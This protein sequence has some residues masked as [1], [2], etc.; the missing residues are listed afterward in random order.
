MKIDIDYGYLFENGII[1]P[2]YLRD[3]QIPLYKMLQHENRMVIDCRRRFGKTTVLLVYIL[4]ECLKR[5]GLKV[6]WGSPE[7]IQ[8]RKIVF[9]VMDQIYSYSPKHKPK[10][11]HFMGAYVYPNNSK[12]YLFGAGDSNELDKCRGQEA[13]IIV[14]DEYG[15]FKF[16]PDYILKSVLNPMLLYTNGQLIMSSTPSNDLTH[17]YFKAVREAQIKGNFFLH[18]IEDS[19][20][21]GDISLEQQQQIIEDCGGVDSEAYQREWLCRV[22]P[23]IS[24]LVI[25]ECSQKTNWLLTENDVRNYHND[26]NYK[27]YH[28][29]LAM[30][31][32]SIDYTCIIYFTYLFDKDV[33]LVEGETVLKNEEVTTKN[34]AEKIREKKQILWNESSIYRAVADNNNPILLRD[35]GTTEKIYFNPIKKDSLIAMVNFARLLF[36]SDRIKISPECSYLVN[37]L[38]F[39]LWNDK[40]TQF[41]RSDSLGHLDA[42]A[43]LIYGVRVVDQ[44]TNPVPFIE[45]PNTFYPPNLHKTKKSSTQIFRSVLKL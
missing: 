20:R 38:K 32:G 8:T 13:D 15:F 41:L 37:C 23:P 34:I 26:I 33:I 31:I 16:D 44:A 25:P 40:R 12:I 39:G 14:L 27:Y 19:I 18:T 2:W 22:I 35:L 3:S 10:Y 45:K 9:P 1:A 30:D 36:Q 4:E 43:S 7:L 6:Y 29:Y 11:D 42:L 28:H 24:S 17:P 5:P 21:Y